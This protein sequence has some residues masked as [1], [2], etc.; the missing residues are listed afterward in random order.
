MESLQRNDDGVYRV[1][2]GCPGLTIGVAGRRANTADYAASP[3]EVRSAEKA[4]LSRVTGAP[5][6]NILALD[7]LHGDTILIAGVPA[8]GREPHI[9]RGGRAAHRCPR[10]LPG[11]THC[12]LRPGIR[13]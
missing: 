5:A 7:Q 10:D 2:G 3:D 11:H 8:R 12:G 13:V 1:Q 6:R 9:R 4:F